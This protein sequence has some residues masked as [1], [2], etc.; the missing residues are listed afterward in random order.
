[1]SLAADGQDGNGLQLEKLRLNFSSCFP[2]SSKKVDTNGRG[3]FSLCLLWLYIE[4]IT[5]P[6]VDTNFIF[7]CSTRYLTSERSERVRYRVEHEKIKFVTTSGH[8]IFCLLYKQQNQRYFSNFP[9][10]SEHFPKISE[11]VRRF[12]KI[13]EG[14]GMFPSYRR[15]CFDHIEMNLGSFD[16]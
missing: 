12:P 16:Y 10:I 2:A 15:R 7:E 6:R 4:D 3:L 9:K 13:S 1:M 11:D 5:C 8:V 14:C